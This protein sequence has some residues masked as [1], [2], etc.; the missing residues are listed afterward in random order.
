MLTRRGGK[1]N[2]Q[3]RPN[4]RLSEMKQVNGLLLRADAS[5]RS[6]AWVSAAKPSALRTIRT[7]HVRSKGTCSQLASVESVFLQILRSP[8]GECEQHTARLKL[9]PSPLATR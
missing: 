8:L 1:R 7:R 5:S 9:L 6:R 2:L 4:K 3:H